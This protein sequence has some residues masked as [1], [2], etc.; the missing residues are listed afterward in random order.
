MLASV[1]VAT[2]DAKALAKSETHVDELDAKSVSGE[3]PL[4]DTSVYFSQ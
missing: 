1:S 2:M 4:S 3:S